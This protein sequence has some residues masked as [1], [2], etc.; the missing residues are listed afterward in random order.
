MTG[1]LDDFGIP[2]RDKP[3]SDSLSKKEA[4][5][6]A[7]GGADQGKEKRQMRRFLAKAVIFHHYILYVVIFLSGFGSGE[8]AWRFYLD[9]W[10]L[11]T[12][13]GGVMGSSTV[14]FWRRMTDYAFD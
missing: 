7:S 12:L 13:I 8:S 14:Y 5:D 3:K 11:V 6:L 4:K 1:P 2:A 9:P 10:V